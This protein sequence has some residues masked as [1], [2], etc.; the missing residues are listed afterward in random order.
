MNYDKQLD[1]WRASMENLTGQ[2][3]L[4][5]ADTYSDLNFVYNS[6][7]AKKYV[8]ASVTLSGDASYTYREST[9]TATFSGEG[10]DTIMD[11]SQ[12]MNKLA[13]NGGFSATQSDANYYGNY[14]SSAVV[15]Q[16]TVI[17]FNG[18]SITLLG[19]NTSLDALVSAGQ[20][21]F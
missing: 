2:A 5:G 4:D 18:G 20:V 7:T 3:D 15:G 6:G 8:E 19:V 21:Q 14:L 9:G 11:W 12:G 13:L 16:D 1:A 17:S 10:V